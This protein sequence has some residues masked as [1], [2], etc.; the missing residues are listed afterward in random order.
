M[1]RLQMCFPVDPVVWAYMAYIRRSLDQ[2]LVGIAR[3]RSEGHRRG[4]LPSYLCVLFGVDMAAVREWVKRG[5]LGPDR[6]FDT[7]MRILEDDVRAF[8]DAGAEYRLLLVH[9]EWLTSLVFE[10]AS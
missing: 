9:R 6:F 10:E 7:R 8:I 1:L 3:I 2:D 5:L 4:Y